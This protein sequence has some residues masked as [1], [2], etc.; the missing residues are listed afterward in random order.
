MT[1][2][3]RHVITLSQII[4]TYFKLRRA[5]LIT[6]IT[7]SLSFLNSLRFLLRVFSHF[8]TYLS[9][10]GSPGGSRGGVG[11]SIVSESSVE[12]SSS[13]D[14]ASGQTSPGA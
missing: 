7:R 14:G 8:V 10:G 1:M 13:V 9:V 11:I 12:P 4:N 6:S 2:N 5:F 3:S